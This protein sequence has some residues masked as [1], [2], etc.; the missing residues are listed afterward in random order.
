MNTP[1]IKADYRTP[2]KECRCEY[3]K[4]R[5]YYADRSELDNVCKSCYDLWLISALP[6]NSTM[7]N[8]HGCV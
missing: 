3:C 2:E 5:Y 1:A 4:I 8:D 6:T 7:G